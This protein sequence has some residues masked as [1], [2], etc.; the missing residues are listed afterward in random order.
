MAK[1]AESILMIRP[2]QSAVLR[3]MPVLSKQYKR[4]ALEDKHWPQPQPCFLVLIISKLLVHPSEHILCPL[5]PLPA[6]FVVVITDLGPAGRVLCPSSRVILL[7]SSVPSPLTRTIASVLH[8]HRAQP[9]TPSSSPSFFKSDFPN[10]SSSCVVLHQPPDLH[11][12]H[13]HS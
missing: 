11:S 8:P 9:P 7:M 3:T 13:T 1:T 2:L 12:H 4:S 6:P 5:P 10:P